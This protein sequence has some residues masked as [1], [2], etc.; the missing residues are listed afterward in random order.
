MKCVGSAGVAD[1]LVGGHKPFL[2]DSYIS[3]CKD[4]LSICLLL[5]SSR[6]AC[7]LA[8]PICFHWTTDIQPTVGRNPSQSYSV[9]AGARA[10]VEAGV[11]VQGVCARDVHRSS[12]L[13][14]SAKPI[15][16]MKSISMLLYRCVVRAAVVRCGWWHFASKPKVLFL[17]RRGR[18]W[19][20]VFAGSLVSLLLLLPPSL[21]VFL[22]RVYFHYS[23]YFSSPH[24]VGHPP[25]RMRGVACSAVP[26]PFDTLP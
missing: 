24:S 21:P 19:S 14:T 6:R 22:G 1:L 23:C 3:W 12:N 5:C 9:G 11:V 15:V 18:P 2:V 26:S 17:Y 7:F 13:F 10:A 4:L 20:V 8:Q 25:R 16:S